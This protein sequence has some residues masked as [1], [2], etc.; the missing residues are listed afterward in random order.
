MLGVLVSER[1]CIGFFTLLEEA[2]GAF[3]R[4][5]YLRRTREAADTFHDDPMII[6]HMVDREL[7]SSEDFTDHIP[8]EL[9]VVRT[10]FLS[11][12]VHFRHRPTVPFVYIM[13]KVQPSLVVDE[14]GQR[15]LQQSSSYP[16]IH[17]YEHQTHSQTSSTCR[18]RETP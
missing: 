18:E 16:A 1:K 7:A 14:G 15:C 6:S 9:D 11:A 3:C 2:L 8:V 13:C 5:S 17:T 10:S 12:V 4:W